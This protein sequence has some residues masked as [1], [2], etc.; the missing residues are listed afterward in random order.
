MARE[1]FPKPR[2]RKLLEFLKKPYKLGAILHMPRARVL[3]IAFSHSYPC[4]R[5][6][7]F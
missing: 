3:K 2:G 1:E 6:K 4:M 7:I 5:N